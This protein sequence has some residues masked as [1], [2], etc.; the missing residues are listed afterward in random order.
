MGEIWKRLAGES[1]FA[2]FIVVDI[3]PVTQTENG[4]CMIDTEV[5]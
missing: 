2:M 3:S 4:I 1:K 5:S